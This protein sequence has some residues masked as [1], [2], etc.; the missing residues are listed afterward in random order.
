MRIVVSAWLV[1]FI[2][3]VS[4]GQKVV[5]L[6]FGFNS[7]VNGICPLAD[8][9]F[10]VFGFFEKAH[11]DSGYFDQNS[12]VIDRAG[13][14]L[15][16]LKFTDREQAEIHE[17]FKSGKGNQYFAWS[18]QESCE[19]GAKGNYIIRFDDSL[20][21]EDSIFYIEHDHTRVREIAGD[22]IRL[23]DGSWFTSY[24]NTA[25]HLTSRGGTKLEYE[26][27]NAPIQIIN[28][29]DTAFLFR[30]IKSLVAGNLEDA[31]A[32]ALTSGD[33]LV[34][35]VPMTNNLY[36]LAG[37]KS[38]TYVSILANPKVKFG[39]S[40]LNIDRID[41]LEYH[42]ELLYLFGKKGTDFVVRT[43]ND[44]DEVSNLAT[45]AHLEPYDFLKSHYRFGNTH[46][47][48][49]SRS[50]QGQVFDFLYIWEESGVNTPPEYSNIALESIGV[51]FVK[52]DVSKYPNIPL[53]DI[54]LKV[55][56]TI[57]NAGKDTLKSWQTHHKG[58]YDIRCD[59]N[60]TTTTTFAEVAPG[61]RY[62]YSMILK[63]MAVEENVNYP[64]CISVSLPNGKVDSLL[65][66]NA[67]CWSKDLGRA[68][69]K[70][71][72]GAEIYPS[73]VDCGAP[74]HCRADKGIVGLKLLAINGQIMAEAKADIPAQQ[75]SLDT[76]GIKKGFYLVEASLKNGYF[77][78][79]KVTLGY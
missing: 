54:N 1:C 5:P 49:I 59:N 38:L 66:D 11:S 8:S 15:K 69:T 47:F 58:I 75:L 53:M 23:G 37:K 21:N 19:S 74:I 35:L 33:T 41:K 17:V 63:D 76:Y 78:Y 57:A 60:L 61:K 73:L 32:P 27:D 2:S 51:E 16:R 6:Q 39:F 44:F 28:Q 70:S 3:S 68:Q 71:Q 30:G 34:D 40:K 26:L 65:F 13:N 42:N 55:N 18:Y 56:I 72:H 43:V 62:K 9:T 77:F 31:L 14:I 24:D 29:S 10:L 52:K 4:W 7:V 45:I 64:L 48:A 46:L 12:I 36:A 79:Q 67:Q 25:L 22:L 50:H 20:S